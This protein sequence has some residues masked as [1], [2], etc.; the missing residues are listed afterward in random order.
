MKKIIVLFVLI[1]FAALG[2]AAAP[3]Q[4]GQPDVCPNRQAVIG[5]YTFI[6]AQL[7]NA[8]KPLSPLSCKSYANIIR[9]WLKRYKYIEVE[10]EIDS[11]WY[12]KTIEFLDYI[13][14]SKDEME[15]LK[16]AKK[17]RSKNYRTLEDNLE[18]A[19]QRFGELLAKPTPVEKKKLEKLR[20]EKHRYDAEKRREQA[21]KSGVIM[22]EED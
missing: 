19:I 3:G 20:A 9:S 15:I 6:N 4:G 14:N 10:T 16:S 11:S 22:P 2:Y 8:D 17:D 5:H 12:N 18:T 1:F 21:K 13:G 7:K